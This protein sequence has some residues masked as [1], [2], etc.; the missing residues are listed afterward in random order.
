M[1]ELYFQLTILD[2]NF[3]HFFSK[4]HVTLFHYFILVSELNVLFYFVFIS[5]L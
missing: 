5:F 3:F 2:F 1:L 4:S